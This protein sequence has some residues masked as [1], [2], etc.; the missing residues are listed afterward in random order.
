MAWNERAVWQSERGSDENGAM[1]RL[2]RLLN[3]LSLFLRNRLHPEEVEFE[4]IVNS[5]N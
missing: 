2:E 3:V 1:V 5:F 4:Q